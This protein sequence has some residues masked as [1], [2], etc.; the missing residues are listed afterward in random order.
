MEQR[1]SLRA[2]PLLGERAA[3]A[4]PLTHPS[5]FPTVESLTSPATTDPP[6]ASSAAAA[7][8]SPRSTRSSPGRRAGK[9]PASK[10]TGFVADAAV[11]INR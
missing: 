2:Q 5:S 7:A 9:P 6:R 8:P 1:E 10:G 11:E 4:P 3:L